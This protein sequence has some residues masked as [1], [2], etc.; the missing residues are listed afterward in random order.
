MRAGKW[1][2]SLTDADSDLARMTR[3]YTNGLSLSARDTSAI[4]YALQATFRQR[5]SQRFQATKVPPSLD[6]YSAKHSAEILSRIF[7]DLSLK[8]M[9]P[10]RQRLDPTE[11]GVR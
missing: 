10:V 8:P 1:I 2:L 7:K 5:E 9:T 6:R 3:D 11:L 4:R